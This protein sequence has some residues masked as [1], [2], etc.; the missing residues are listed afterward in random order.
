M[1]KSKERIK[2][3]GSKV[4]IQPCVFSDSEPLAS[5]QLLLVYIYMQMSCRGP[6]PRLVAAG[7]S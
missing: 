6:W 5:L 7:C 1:S 3:G 4:D 2:K